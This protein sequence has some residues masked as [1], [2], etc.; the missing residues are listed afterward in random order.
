LYKELVLKNPNKN[1]VFSPLSI[2]VA[3]A[4]LSLGA[5]SN[6]LEE[7]LEG[8]KFNLTETPEADIHQGFG[9]L[10]PILS[11]PEDQVQISIGSTMF[12][13]KSLQILAEFKEKAR[14]L[15]QAEASTANFQQPH[16]AK[17]LIND[18]VSKQTQGKI[19]ELIS[20]LDERTVMVLVNYIYF[21]GAP[22]PA[23]IWHSVGDL[24][25]AA[26]WSRTLAVAF[27]SQSADQPSATS[28]PGAAVSQLISL[29]SATFP[30]ETTAAGRAQPLVDL[31]FNLSMRLGVR[32]EVA[33]DRNSAQEAS[34]ENDRA[35]SKR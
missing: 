9:H 8:L 34:Q 7:I 32:K 30:L 26:A 16:E 21:K 27:P 5:S 33:Q 31:G 12:V 24:T 13:E 23:H 19:K 6:T 29:A 2:S 10:L 35:T 20:E 15:Y 25:P 1:V 3:L 4:I 14:A 11:Q 18:Y 22:D 28:N 17:K